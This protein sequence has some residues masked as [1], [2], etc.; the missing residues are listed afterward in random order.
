MSRLHNFGS[1]AADFLGPV[2]HITIVR[3]SGVKIDDC[4][5]QCVTPELRTIAEIDCHER[6]LTADLKAACAEARARFRRIEKRKRD[7]L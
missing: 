3:S 4:R 2:V 6:L 1:I 7:P 5:F